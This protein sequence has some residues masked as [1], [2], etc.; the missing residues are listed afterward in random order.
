VVERGRCRGMWRVDLSRIGV[1]V[2]LPCRDEAGAYRRAPKEFT[3]KLDKYLPKSKV[4][5]EPE[6]S[7]GGR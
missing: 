4:Y 7:I 5:L 3:L 2:H 1:R 6:N